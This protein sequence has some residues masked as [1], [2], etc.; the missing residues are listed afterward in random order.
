MDA[1]RLS[2]L[3]ILSQRGKTEL[4]RFKGFLC[5]SFAF[6]APSRWVSNSLWQILNHRLIDQA[7]CCAA[8]GALAEMLFFG[9]Q[10]FRFVAEGAG[11]AYDRP[12]GGEDGFEGLLAFESDDLHA[13]APGEPFHLVDREDEQATVVGERGDMARAVGA[14]RRQDD[15][16]VLD[17]QEGFAGFL[18]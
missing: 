12:F 14:R 13:L 1:L 16:A 6:F 18:S 15:G 2:T 5:E 8:A 17:C 3:Q 7:D 11:D 10:R 9:K 4:F